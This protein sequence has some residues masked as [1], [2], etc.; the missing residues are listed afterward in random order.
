VVSSKVKTTSVLVTFDF[1]PACQLLP[2]AHHAG[3]SFTQRSK[4]G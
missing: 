4:N 2:A 3:I 1:F